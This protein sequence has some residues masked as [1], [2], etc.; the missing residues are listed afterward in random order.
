MLLIRIVFTMISILV[1][2]SPALPVETSPPA[3][4]LVP[5]NNKHD[6]TSNEERVEITIQDSHFTAPSVQSQPETLATLAVPIV[7]RD[8]IIVPKAD[9]SDDTCI[10]PPDAGPCRDFV[11]R[12]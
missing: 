1:S 5:F 2:D 6:H 10:L 9:E 7:P 3:S 11:H 4:V 12:W 8:R